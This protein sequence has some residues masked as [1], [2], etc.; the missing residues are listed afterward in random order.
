MSLHT[1]FYSNGDGLLTIP[2]GKDSKLAC[3]RLSLTDSGHYL[4]PCDEFG[5]KKAIPNGEKVSLCV[6]HHL[7][8]VFAFH[9]SIAPSWR[10]ADIHGDWAMLGLYLGRKDFELDSGTV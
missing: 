4:L 9:A 8:K 10:D 1:D 5:P 2:Q 6:N 7:D 3:L